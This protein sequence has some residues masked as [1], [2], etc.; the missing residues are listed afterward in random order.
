LELKVFLTGRVVVEADDLLID[1]SGFPGR[2][3]RLLFAYLVVE[4]G[5]PV[6]RDELARALWGDT[7][8][9]TWEKALTVILSKLRGLLVERGVDGANVLTG[10]FGCYR[11]NLPAGTWVDVIAA[12]EAAREA[13]GALAADDL[14][15]AKSLA[16]RAV[17]LAQ[18][19]FLAG[20]EG[21]WVAGKRRELVEVLG[22]GLAC[23][24]DAS[25]R[26]GETGEAAKW[27]EELIVLERY[28]ETGYR[29]L[30]EAHA[31]AGNRAEERSLHRRR[32]RSIGP[33]SSA[34]CR[35]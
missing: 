35:I 33:F 17:S 20:E 14:G 10:A 2:Q 11:L 18:P 30:M 28:R 8:P 9:A 23:L 21:D 5:R 26:S 12:A 25:L 27:A 32:S 31:T 13:E 4:Q 3:S 6:P 29:L 22:R 15:R 1:E 34:I 7:P 16:T 24:S 19:P